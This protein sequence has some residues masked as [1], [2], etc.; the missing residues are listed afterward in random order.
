MEQGLFAL[1]LPRNS[2]AGRHPCAD[3]AVSLTKDFAGTVCSLSGTRL[4]W[5]DG[6]HFYAGVCWEML[7]VA[8]EGGMLRR[9]KIF[10]L[11]HCLLSEE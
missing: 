9:E 1:L 2:C 8:G 6:L 7:P 10:F 3:A 4:R 11:Q 5:S